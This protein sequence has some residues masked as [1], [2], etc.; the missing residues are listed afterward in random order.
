MLAQRN[1]LVFSHQFWQPGLSISYVKFLYSQLIIT[2]INTEY[3]DIFNRSLLFVYTVLEVVLY[4]QK[5]SV[6]LYLLTI[7]SQ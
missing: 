3:K 5:T 2:T 6:P 1:S 4:R 7:T